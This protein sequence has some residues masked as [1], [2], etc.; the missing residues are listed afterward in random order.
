MQA[1][2]PDEIVAFLKTTPLFGGLSESALE[3]L[4]AHALVRSYP[5]GQIIFMQGDRG[6]ALYLVISGRLKVYVQSERGDEMVLVTLGPPSTFGEL[7]LVDGEPRSATVEVV[8]ACRLLVLERDPV[9]KLMRED[10]D[11]DDAFLRSLGAL[12]R[13]LT[14]LAGDLVFLDLHGRVAKLLVGFCD[15]QEAFGD[16]HPWILDLALTQTDLARMVGGTRQ[17]VNQILRSFEARG[18]LEM[19]RRRI[20]LKKIDILRRRAEG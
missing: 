8:E 14:D 15:E 17:S 1:T 20:T 18:Y 4:S 6:D 11:V 9:R 5:R 13:R 10:P 19:D 2:K 7:A 3:A 12:V 16:A